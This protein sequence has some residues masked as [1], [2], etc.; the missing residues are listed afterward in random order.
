M[1]TTLLILTAVEIEC[2]KE[3]CIDCQHWETTEQGRFCLATS[4]L[5]ENGRRTLGCHK[6]EKRAKEMP[7]S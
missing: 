3:F 6:A 4:E 5:I 1:K 7:K 2:G